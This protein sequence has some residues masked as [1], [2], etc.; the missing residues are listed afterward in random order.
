MDLLSIIIFFAVIA[1]IFKKNDPKKY[2]ETVRK[3]KDIGG[4]VLGEIRGEMK[5]RRENYEKQYR[6]FE[7]K[8]TRGATQK[9]QANTYEMPKHTQRV[10]SYEMPTQNARTTPAYEQVNKSR[11]EAEKTSILERAKA[12]AEEDKEDI[13][14][15]SL[16]ESHGHSAKVAPAIHDHSEDIISENSVEKIQDLIV[17]GYEVDLCF[18]RD[19]LGEAMDMVNRFSMGGSV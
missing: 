6:D 14:L 16:E 8:V 12:N 1:K 11:M 19:F 10:N 5:N 7:Q 9:Q 17:K 13:T 4:E 15:R 2:E 18:E 3:A